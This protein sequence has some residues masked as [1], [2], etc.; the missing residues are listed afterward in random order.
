MTA[1]E[2]TAG[3]PRRD[4]VRQAAAL[5]GWHVATDLAEVTVLR[6][7]TRSVRVR[8]SVLGSVVS[9]STE[10]RRFDGR[11]RLGQVLT[12]LARARR[13]AA[14]HEPVTRVEREEDGS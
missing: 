10:L 7:G 2:L 8:W 5:H 1:T 13:H 12:E 14:R 6:R 4:L 9:A 3:T 11:D